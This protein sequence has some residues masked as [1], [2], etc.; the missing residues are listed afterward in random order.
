MFSKGDK[1]KIFSLPLN[2]FCA[3]FLHLIFVFSDAKAQS[4][5]QDLPST[6]ETSSTG[7]PSLA[8]VLGILCC[9]MSG[10]TFI[11]LAYMKFCQRRT[12]SGRGL[13]QNQQGIFGRSSRFSGIDKTVIESLPFFRFSALK[14]SKEGLECA[15]CLSKFE[16][17]EILRLLPK[18]KHAFHIDC[19]D[20]WLEKHSTC[21][22]CRQRVSSEDLK[23]IAYSNSMRYL[24]NDQSEPRDESNMEIF[25]QREEGHR[26]SSRFSIGRSSRKIEK[27]LKLLIQE[28]D[29]AKSSEDNEIFHKQNHKILVS[30]FVFKQRWSSVS[31]SD[32]MFLN[33]EMLNHFTSNRFSSMDSNQ[34]QLPTSGEIE[35]EENMKIFEDMEAK[36]LY[37]SQDSSST[38]NKTS[39][40][41]SIPDSSSS[42]TSISMIHEGEKR[43]MSEITA[44]SRNRKLGMK[45]NSLLNSSLSGNTVREDRMRQ[46]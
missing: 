37:D 28:E 41:V 32:I 10:L 18:C 30:N 16:D 8:V 36:R 26:G 40:S 31:S 3:I 6:S 13:P 34:K 45:N 44:L 9:I 23:L 19:I 14:G 2:Q 42:H 27:E 1:F 17:V 5:A 22:L 33:S 35:D 29:D 43:S 15:V 21:P 24:W 39:T 38:T 25:V 20:Y 4:L 46:L 11:L 7:Q 12:S